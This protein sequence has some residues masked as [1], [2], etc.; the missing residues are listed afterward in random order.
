MSDSPQAVLQAAIGD[1][2]SF[3]PFSFCQDGVAAP[4]MGIRVSQIANAL[5]VSAIVVVVDEGRD[6]RF[7]IAGQSVPMSDNRPADRRRIV[8]LL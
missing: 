6:L 3:D 7:E 5:V 1:G 8:N 2:L 4:E